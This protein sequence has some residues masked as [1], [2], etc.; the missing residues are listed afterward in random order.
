MELLSAD[1]LREKFLMIAHKQYELNSQVNPEWFEARYP[2]YRALW[3][4]AAEAMAYFPWEWW[5]K[6]SMSETDKQQLGLE[7]AD[8]L[9][10][11]VSMLLSEAMMPVVRHWQQD[12]DDEAVSPARETCFAMVA[13]SAAKA[14]RYIM[15]DAATRLSDADSLTYLPSHI[16]LVA[17]EALSRRFN[18]QALCRAACALGIGVEGLIGLYFGKNVLNK[19]RQDHGYKTGEYI[20]NWRAAFGDGPEMMEDNIALAQIVISM[21]E[22]FS[23]ALPEGTTYLMFLGSHD[24]QKNLYNNLEAAYSNV[25]A[26]AGRL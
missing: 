9:H 2:F 11:G 20:K 23:W 17:K 6:R 10:F 4:E 16:E 19:F 24:Y 7:L 25:L 5:K 12:D 21:E 8:M 26:G 15:Q 1:V 13:S 3:T 22:S 14:A 18:L